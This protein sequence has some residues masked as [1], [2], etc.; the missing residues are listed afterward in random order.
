M[1]ALRRQAMV[2]ETE[3]RSPH[4]ACSAKKLNNGC[5][6]LAQLKKICFNDAPDLLLF[7]LWHNLPIHTLRNRA[8]EQ[9]SAALIRNHMHLHAA[10]T[11]TLPI[12]RH[13]LWVAAEG[14]N[15]VVNPLECEDLILEARIQVAEGVGRE[16]RVCKEAKGVKPVV[17]GD[18]DHVWRLVDP[19]LERPVARVAVDVALNMMSKLSGSLI[20]YQ[21]Q[22]LRREYRRELELLQP[23]SIKVYQREGGKAYVCFQLLR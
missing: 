14:G 16:V 10:R 1:D 6:K 9:R 2:D 17:D 12:D 19:V 18:D 21:E 11:R 15:V 22:Y 20:A 3:S 13:A 5:N 4:P 23:I 8:R 7:W